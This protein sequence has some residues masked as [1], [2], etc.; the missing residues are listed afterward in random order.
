MNRDKIISDFLGFENR[1]DPLPDFHPDKVSEKDPILET[2][3]MEDPITHK[4]RPD[5]SLV[6][7]SNVSDDVKQYIRSVLMTV[8]SDT[9]PIAPDHETAEAL[10]KSPWETV[11][12]YYDKV[13]SFVD[14]LTQSKSE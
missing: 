12:S 14:N 8:Q 4:P 1:V 2:I 13:K 6:Y 10:H 11:E 9:T 7:S 5:L 3:F